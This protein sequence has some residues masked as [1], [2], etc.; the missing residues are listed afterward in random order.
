LW[1]RDEPTASHPSVRWS[2]VAAW[3]GHEYRSAMTWS[4]ISKPGSGT[5]PSP[6]EGE[7]EGG[8]LS[9]PL[10]EALAEILGEFTSTPERCWFA[11]WTGYADVY[12]RM[13]EETP[14]LRIPKREFI[15]YRAPLHAMPTFEFGQFRHSFSMAWPDD[16]SWFVGSESDLCS[17][18]VGASAP[19]II[20]ILTD[21][22]LEALPMLPNTPVSDPQ[23]HDNPSGGG[24]FV[25]S[26]EA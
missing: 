6:W 13:T 26:S 7:P 5:S 20:R 12:D 25:A 17:T 18:Y 24:G 19:C 14:T 10:R 3:T 4:E 1:T 15:L 11:V 23:S 16:R 2:T 8:H 9:P 22:R 21:G